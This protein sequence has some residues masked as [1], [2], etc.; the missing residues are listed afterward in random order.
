MR[1]LV[2]KLE[3]YRRQ[4]GSMQNAI[5]AA[6]KTCEQMTIDTEKKCA[7]MLRDAEQA[8]AEK[9]QN[10]GSRIEEEQERLELAKDAAA[11]AMPERPF[12]VY[13]DMIPSSTDMGDLST[14]MP[15][16]H[17]YCPGAK[18][19]GHGN[20]YYIVDPYLACVQNAKWQVTMLTL[21]LENGAERAKKV[22]SEFKPYFKS[23]EEFLAHLDSVNTCGD[24]I[25]YKEDGSAEIKLY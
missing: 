20:D 14:I 22:I 23:K 6:Q 2:E 17:P 7:Q 19:K 4:E 15:V 10:V 5:L 9:T 21:L 1:I 12:T 3:E 25:V 16:V 13:H 24:R 18:G 11:I 8:V